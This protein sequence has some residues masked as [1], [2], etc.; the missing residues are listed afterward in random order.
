MDIILSLQLIDGRFQIANKNKVT[1]HFAEIHFAEAI[2][3][4]GHFAEGAISPN[5]RFAENLFILLFFHYFI[6]FQKNN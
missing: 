1:V 2:S 4:N 5:G 3:P 6:N